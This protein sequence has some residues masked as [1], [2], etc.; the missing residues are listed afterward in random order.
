MLA[1]PREWRRGEALIFDD[2]FEHEVH[3][4]G[5]AARAVLLLH[6]RHPMLMGARC[7]VRMTVDDPC[8]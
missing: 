3:H 7:P 6:F 1:P 8:G 2:S 4:R 5:A